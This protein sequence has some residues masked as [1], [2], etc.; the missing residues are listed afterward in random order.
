MGLRDRLLAIPLE[1]Q[2][3]Y[4]AEQN[5]LFIN[6]ERLA[7][8]SHQDIDNVRREIERKLEPLGKIVYGIVNYDNFVIAP[9]LVDP[10]TAMVKGVVERYYWGVT[11][12]TTSNFLRL[13]LGKA[14]SERGL[15]PHIYE[16]AEEAHHHLRDFT[17]GDAADATLR[18][19]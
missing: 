14:L 12:Y 2:F 7:I 15:A 19:A 3:A 17:S 8:R 10:W 6:F 13:K 5:V 18:S 9:D 1:R 16:S 11:R 4:A